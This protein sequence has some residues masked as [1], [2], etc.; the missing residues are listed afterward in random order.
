[1]PAAITATGPSAN[2]F[3]AHSSPAHASRRPGPMPGHQSAAR[4]APAVRPGK[5]ATEC[6]WRM[7]RQKSTTSSRN[8]IL[9]PEV[10]CGLP[11]IRRRCR[12]AAGGS[13]A[14]NRRPASPARRRGSGR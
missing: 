12:Y 5:R 7:Y 8:R 14:R 1:M 2:R 6:G 3:N 13:P 10:G 4:L 11:V 9:R